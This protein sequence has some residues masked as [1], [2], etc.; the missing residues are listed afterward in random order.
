MDPILG[1][2]SIERA[3]ADSVITIPGYGDSSAAA[4]E[5][6]GLLRRLPTGGYAL[7]GEAAKQAAAAPAAPVAQESAPALAPDVAADAMRDVRGLSPESDAVVA[8]LASV[9]PITVESMIETAARGGEVDYQTIGKSMNDE[10]AAARLEQAVNETRHAGIRVLEHL[11][12]DPVAFE[13]HVRATNPELASTIT[14]D[15]F[16]NRST[17]SLIRAA[18][19]F[20]ADRAQR[21]AQ[22]A[23]SK[24]VEAKVENGVV[25]FKRSD[26]GLAPTPRR[27]DFGGDLWISE[28]AARAAGLI[29][30][31]EQK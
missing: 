2:V 22:I 19:S 21:I 1:P 6:M 5:Q 24:N 16:S 27:G 4:F 9:S 31:V 18:Q 14:R 11:E 26:L 10:G 30:V 25:M 12:V 20:K 28:T 7:D 3:K 17:E 23:T 15:M 13:A 29:D 8:K